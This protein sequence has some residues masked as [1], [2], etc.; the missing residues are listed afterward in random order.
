MG[1]TMII[2]SHHRALKDVSHRVLYMKEAKIIKIGEPKEI[3]DAFLKD[4]SADFKD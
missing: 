2:V 1:V 4:V 3:Y